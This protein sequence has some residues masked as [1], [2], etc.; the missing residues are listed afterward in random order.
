[1]ENLQCYLNHAPGLR[2]PDLPK[3]GR[4]YLHVRRIE[5]DLIE[6]IEK[7]AA[8]LHPERLARRNLLH[9]RKVGVVQGRTADNVATGVPIEPQW[10]LAHRDKRLRIEKLIDE[11][12]AVRMVQRDVVI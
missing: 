1:P 12:V 6:G 4:R 5:V 9:Q 8:Q 10:Q 11:S 7:F 2:R 3:A